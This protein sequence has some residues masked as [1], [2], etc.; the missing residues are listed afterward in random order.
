MRICLLLPLLLCLPFSPKAQRL[1]YNQYELLSREDLK[2]GPTTIDNQ[3]DDIK[4]NAFFSPQWLPATAITEKG[5]RYTGLKLKLDLYRNAFFA[6]V[7]DTLYDL[8]NAR[9]ARFI[10]YPSL[11]DTTVNYVFQ[12]GFSIGTIRPDKYVQVL[13]SGRLTLLKQPTLEIREVNED[14]PLSKVKKFVSQDYYYLTTG[15]GQ[16]TTVHLNRKTLE[17]EMAD[18]WNEVS[19]YAKEKDLSF[20][21]E[22]GWIYLVK[23][24]NSL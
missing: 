9:V 23:F 12:K 6:N 1:E 20:T 4:G 22:Q 15:D 7:H 24:Y 21:E 14:S 11:A 18:K 3:Y 10:L 5:T 2:A 13:A 17:K 16:G 19:R 8:T